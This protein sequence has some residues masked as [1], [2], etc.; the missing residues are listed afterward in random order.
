MV[1]EEKKEE[2]EKE[3]LEIQTNGKIFT[4]LE[5]EQKISKEFRKLKKIIKNLDKD[6]KMLAIPLIENIAFCIIQ[7]EELRAVVKRDGYFEKYQNGANQHGFKKSVASDML[8]SVGKNYATLL[9]RL[10]EFLPMGDSEL[11][12]LL[13]FERKHKLK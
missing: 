1:T 2:V 13:I 4:D 6:R 9:G 7:L 8:I 3:E 5:R 10:K 12:A 11:D